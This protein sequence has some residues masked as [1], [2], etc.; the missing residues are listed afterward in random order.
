MR[1]I[2]IFG[3]LL[4]ASCESGDRIGST[5]W[6]LLRTADRV[7]VVPDV[8]A[9]IHPITSKG[10]ID[11]LAEFALRHPSG[12]STPSSTGRQSKFRVIFYSNVTPI[13][14]FDVGTDF[15]QSQSPRGFQIR[16]LSPSELRELT[17]LLEGSSTPFESNAAT[18][19]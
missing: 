14:E 18:S 11:G 12:W 17:N 7:M 8:V 3:A 9:T 16:A 15:L 10:R 2:I 6:T 5:D 1:A 13:G 19:N 4:L